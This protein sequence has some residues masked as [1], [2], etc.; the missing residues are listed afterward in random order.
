MGERVAPIPKHVY[1][2][3]IHVAVCFLKRE[4]ATE[5]GL[6][7]K[8]PKLVVMKKMQAHAQKKERANWSAIQP[9]MSVR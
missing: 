5:L 8:R 7:S 1:M 2:N 6:I 3:I 9:K 4:V